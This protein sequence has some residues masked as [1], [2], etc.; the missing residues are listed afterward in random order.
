VLGL[1]ATVP[2]GMSCSLKEFARNA[3]SSL[4]ERVVWYMNTNV[5]L[6]YVMLC[7]GLFFFKFYLYEYS[8]AVFRHTR[9][10]HQISLQMVM[11]HHVV[12]GN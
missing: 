5:G 4:K 6:C 11:S 8:V 7:Y 12:A 3:K 10:G 9:R 1:R 2:R